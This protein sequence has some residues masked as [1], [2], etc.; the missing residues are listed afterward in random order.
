MQIVWHDDIYVYTLAIIESYTFLCVNPLSGSFLYKICIESDY[1]SEEIL[2]FIAYDIVN[3]ILI[4]RLI[5]IYLSLL[6]GTLSTFLLRNTS[7]P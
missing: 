3:D 2:W 1:I 7:E 6:I 5:L 4:H